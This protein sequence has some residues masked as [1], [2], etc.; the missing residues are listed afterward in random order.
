MNHDVVRVL[1]FLGII[2]LTYCAAA[3]MVIR[4]WM[5]RS[6]AGERWLRRVIYGAALA[7]VACMAYGY[8]VEPYWPQVTHVT[9]DASR[10]DGPRPV[11]IVQI[12]DLHCNAKPRLE[13]ELPRIIAAQKPDLIVF[14]GDAIN[15][16]AGLPV[17]K[18]CM[19]ALAREAPTYAVR[20]NWDV[21][22]W[23]RV[24]LFGGTGVRELNGNAV[25]VSVAG[26]SFWIAGAACEDEAAIH[27]ALA[28]IPSGA[29]SV[30]LYHSP[31]GALE[32]AR[33]GAKVC[34]VGDTHGGQV[35][36]PFYGALTTGER[37][38]K[39]FEA[40]LYRVGPMWLYV[41]RGIGMTGG[42]PPVRFCAR[43]E[44][45]VLTLRPGS[46]HAGA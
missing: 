9:I 35:A 20:G 21:D 44:V 11:R 30:F 41:N 18:R 15:S 1:I 37:F 7:G 17:F 2:G 22:Y 16:L 8:F 3:V 36:L 6:R 4:Q 43:P 12:S 13:G 33:G 45:T 5:G 46:L 14:T 42:L 34:L 32:I 19:T 27:R 39:R 23:S 40:G 10:L 38:G 26:A 29:F 24:D 28:A 25:K 31:S